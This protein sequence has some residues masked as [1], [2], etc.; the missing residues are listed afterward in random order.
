MHPQTNVI[1]TVFR[2]SESAGGNQISGTEAGGATAPRANTKD[3]FDVLDV[4]AVF[5][6]ALL[7]L[8]ALY[9]TSWY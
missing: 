6:A 5:A 9:Q 8:T 7:A 3:S 2:R 1:S 4:L